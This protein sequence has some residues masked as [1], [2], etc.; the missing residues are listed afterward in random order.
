MY[1]VMIM[2][3]YYYIIFYFLAVSLAAVL[4]T[5][6]DKRAAIRGE[7]RISEK[8][9][10]A[11]ALCGGAA[12]MYITMLKIRHKTLH[13]RFMLGLPLIILLQAGTVLLILLDKSAPLA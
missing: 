10:F 6:W 8:M 3:P 9:L 12:A 5:A 4:L 13:K 1:A 7:S 2:K 11:T